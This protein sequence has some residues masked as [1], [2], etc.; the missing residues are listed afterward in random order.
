MN[1]IYYQSLY[2][3][4]KQ[5]H[6]NGFDIANILQSVVPH[7]A[8]TIEV[9]AGCA[10]TLRDAFTLDRVFLIGTGDSKEARD[11]K[12]WTAFV[13]YGLVGH[14]YHSNRTVVIRN[15]QTDPRWSSLLQ[16]DFMPQSGSAIGVPLSKNEQTFGVLMY[17]HP[18][19]DYFTSE[20]VE[21]L[22]EVA[23]VTSDALAQAHEF[24]T[25][26][27]G[28]TSY[29]T[30]FSHSLVPILL[31]DIQG[32]VVDAND[33]A[34]EFLGFSVDTLRGIPLADLNIGTIG[35][36][37]LDFLEE[38]EET[39]FRN[40][41][42]DIDGKTIPTLIRVRRLTINNEARL[43]WMFQD[44]RMQMELEQLRRDLTS[45]VYHDMRQPLT[46]VLASNMKL[47]EILQDH[48]NRA[49]PRML[50]LGVRSAQRIQRMVESLLDI[51]RLEDHKAILNIA[52]IKVG[53]L[54]TDAVALVQPI[55]T[56]SQQTISVSIQP[57]TPMTTLDLDMVSRVAVNLI[58]NAIKYTPDGGNIHVKA[59][60]D[61]EFI[62]IT[63]ADS[64]PG[65]PASMKNRVFDK[66][67]RV[68]Y[69]DAPKGI[70]LGLAFCRLAVEAH[71]GTIW[72]E[73]D[74]KN[75]SDF[76]F[77]LPINEPEQQDSPDDEESSKEEARA[78][79]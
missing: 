78:S 60:H 56:E 6:N 47:R 75:G 35:D 27:K 65:I 72:V 42:Y 73:S 43:E 30:L 59:T 12:Q 46:T 55:A 31:T 26:S 29:T 16:M 54:L 34:S 2:K 24:T 8:K 37:G 41:L 40:T 79:A 63:I 48:D 64:G 25:T 28:T 53:D 62:K 58:E 5:L 14:V 22:N 15:V 68:K 32:T 21:Y 51:Q 1:T 18:K 38:G 13:R 36:A 67:S 44:M 20:R 39:N 3:L 57:D 17:I 33:E 52:P 11:R 4:S 71:G 45:M 23:S 61:S 74:G 50:E 19:V 9:D 76:I 70:G 66:F 10:M 77:T 69:Q 7:A 49:I